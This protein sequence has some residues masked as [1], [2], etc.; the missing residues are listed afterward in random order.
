MHF[1]VP[2]EIF[3]TEQ[4]DACVTRTKVFKAL[5]E[6]KSKE[7]KR[8]GRR[9]KDKKEKEKRMGITPQLSEINSGFV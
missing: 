7:N 9:R 6:K 5:D 8:K 1:I 4:E 3:L 2:R